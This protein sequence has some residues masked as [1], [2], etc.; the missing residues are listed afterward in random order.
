[1]YF[2]DRRALL[3]ST[4]DVYCGEKPSLRMVCYLWLEGEAEWRGIRIDLS[5][6]GRRLYTQYCG[7]LA[8]EHKTPDVLQIT[9][10]KSTPNNKTGLLYIQ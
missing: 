6:P 4:I 5:L 10:N 2:C 9:Q 3:N 1:M 7:N 8:A